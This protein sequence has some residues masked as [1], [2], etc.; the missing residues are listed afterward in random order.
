MLGL[1]A[2][3][4]HR[5]MPPPTTHGDNP[6]ASPSPSLSSPTV[7]AAPTSGASCASTRQRHLLSSSELADRIGK[8]LPFCS[9]L[10]PISDLVV[11]D[12]AAAATVAEHR[13][14]KS[15]TAI[16]AALLQTHEN[17]AHESVAH[18]GDRRSHSTE[19]SSNTTLRYFQQ[20]GGLA[21]TKSTTHVA[22]RGSG[23][24]S[25][26][27]RDTHKELGRWLQQRRREEETKAA[28]LAITR[29]HI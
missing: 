22:G 9:L 24:S 8:T 11:I 1:L 2:G 27:I 5:S 10:V 26:T 16:S 14:R 21:A 6:I 17:V 25:E 28:H 15:L 19:P 29:R 13:L 3:G 4:S 23:G 20:R 7:A 18:Q 12:H